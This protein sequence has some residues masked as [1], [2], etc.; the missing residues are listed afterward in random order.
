MKVLLTGAGGFVGQ[1][2]IEKLVQNGHAVIA[3]DQQLP[4]ITDESIL[5]IEGDLTS[6]G[7]IDRCFEHKPEAIIHLAALPGGAAESDPELSFAVNVEASL[8]LMRRASK[9]GKTRFVYASTI[10]VIGDNMPMDGVYDESALKPSLHYGI[11]KNMMEVALEGLSRRGDI[12]GI[13][14]RLPGILARPPGPSGLKSAFLSELFYAVENG[15]P[16]TL[17]MSRDSTIWA[18]SVDQCAENFVHAISIDLSQIGEKRTLTLPAIYCTL[19]G[20]SETILAHKLQS[21]NLISYEPDERLQAIFGSHPELHARASEAL[22]FNH[23]GTLAKLVENI[24]SR[25]G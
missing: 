25:I 11:H 22:G 12:D 5:T 1:V 18:M 15:Q 24:Y 8:Y 23:D 9:L 2:V 13:G 4:T 3:T 14:L 7:I 6:K 20:L 10:A 17:P 19:Q 21:P 16:I